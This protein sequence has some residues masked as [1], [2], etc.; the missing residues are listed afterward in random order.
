MTE[1]CTP[2][3]HGRAR[4]AKGMVALRVHDSVGGFM[5][6]A[7]RLA[8]ALKGRWSGRE[9]AYILSPSKLRRFEELYAAGWDAALKFDSIY[10]THYELEAPRG[11]AVDPGT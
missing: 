11:H 8:Q 10:S 1:P 7:A 3:T 2:Y 5:G 9:H 6:R 4:Y